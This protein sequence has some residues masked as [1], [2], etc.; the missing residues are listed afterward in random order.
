[1]HFN[2]VGISVHAVPSLE[3]SDEERISLSVEMEWLKYWSKFNPL[4][5]SSRGI[6]VGHFSI[7]KLAKKS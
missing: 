3:R 1:M 4:Q 7:F 2:L 6:A 5:S